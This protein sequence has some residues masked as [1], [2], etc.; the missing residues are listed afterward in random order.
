M[1]YM[2]KKF[3]VN[4]YIVH[5]FLKIHYELSLQYNG[6]GRSKNPKSKSFSAAISVATK[7]NFLADQR[8]ERD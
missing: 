4:V 3:I 7:L 1:V 8:C 5:I 2:M 6:A